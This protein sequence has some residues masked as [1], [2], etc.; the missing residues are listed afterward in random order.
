MV[1]DYKSG[2]YFGELALITNEP[3]AA[4]V[5]A[6]TDVKMISMDRKSFK[7]LLGPITEIF[8]RNI[9]NYYSNN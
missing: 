7:R 3:R 4:F 5:I 9:D 8:K 6:K 2:E 1:K